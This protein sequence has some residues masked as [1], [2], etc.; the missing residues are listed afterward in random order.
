MDRLLVEIDLYNFSTQD[1]AHALIRLANDLLENS[2]MTINAEDQWQKHIA[3]SYL[4]KWRFE[5]IPTES[6]IKNNYLLRERALA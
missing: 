4:L 3:E 5:E 1:A 6:E 2:T